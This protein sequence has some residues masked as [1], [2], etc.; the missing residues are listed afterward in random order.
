MVDPKLI[1][2]T[3]INLNKK[4]K[5]IKKGDNILLQITGS[6]TLDI[7]GIIEQLTLNINVTHSTENDES[8]LNV[9]FNNIHLLEKTLDA[10]LFGIGDS[11]TGLSVKNNEVRETTTNE[12][13]AKAKS[14]I[15]GSDEYKRQLESIINNSIESN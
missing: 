3:S 4:P 7:V 6:A 13:L 2:V 12:I 5:E 15:L 1:K 9:Q 14:D 11:R 8:S 10:M